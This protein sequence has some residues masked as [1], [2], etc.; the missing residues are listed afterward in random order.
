MISG[1]HSFLYIHT[2]ISKHIHVHIYI[3]TCL[4]MYIY[5]YV[6]TYTPIIHQE[7][8]FAVNKP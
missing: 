5:I 7:D 8:I 3:Y 4:Y 2:Y 6:Y 1:N